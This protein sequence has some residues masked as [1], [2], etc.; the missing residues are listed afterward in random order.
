MFQSAEK[1][2]AMFA[3][4]EW[5]SNISTIWCNLQQFQLKVAKNRSLSFEKAPF[6][7][8]IVHSCTSGPCVSKPLVIILIEMT[9]EV[10]I[11]A[12]GTPNETANVIWNSQYLRCPSSHPAVVWCGPPPNQNLITHQFLAKS[13]EK[14]QRNRWFCELFKN[15][16]ENFQII[17]HFSGISSPIRLKIG[18]WIGL[19]HRMAHTKLQPDWLED[20]RDIGV[21][22][23]AFAV[24]R[25]VHQAIITGLRSV[26]KGT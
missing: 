23:A 26:F 14:W 6:I 22:Y 9:C 21:F 7:N 13:V 5:P 4:Q 12:L 3:E 10:C 19:W 24:S 11:T 8:V 17:S 1:N 18:V 2:L 15:K 20:T 16:F 25:G